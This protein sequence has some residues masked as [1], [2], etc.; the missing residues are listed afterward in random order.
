MLG[1][2]LGALILVPL[3][4]ITR[5][6]LGHKGTGIDMMIYGALIT[7]ISVYQPKGV[8]GFRAK[9]G[10]RAPAAALPPAAP[11]APPSVLAA[12]EGGR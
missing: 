3:S 8:W 2:A 5:V 11:P 12:G 7:L 4:E 10:R 9:L 6:K 1:P